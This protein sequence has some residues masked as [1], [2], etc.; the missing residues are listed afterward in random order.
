VAGARPRTLPAALSAVFAGAGAAL[1]GGSL[2]WDRTLLAAVV[3]LSLQV[4]VNYAN[5]YSDGIRG[6]DEVRSGPV[7]LVGQHLVA[8]KKVKVA[9]FG[10]F[11]VAGVAGLILAA[12]AGWWLIAVGVA[13]ILAAWYYTGGKHPY[14]YAGYG[15]VFTFV[16]FG[17]VATLGTEYVNLGT[18]TRVGLLSALGIGCLITALL[19]VN[20][21]RDI[22]GDRVSGKRT[23]A[24]R[25]SDPA[26]RKLYVV[27][28]GAGVVLGATA[29][30]PSI[31]G[32]T[33]LA[34]LALAIGPLHSVVKGAKA[35]KLIAVLGE[36]GRVTLV[37]GICM[38]GSAI[39]V[40]VHP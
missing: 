2:T 5:D 36:T 28:V 12:L 8:P 29:F 3:A 33:Q 10:A 1:L 18:V 22:P 13:S 31:A 37:A 15:E 25:M 30:V 35:K 21:L 39:I 32:L 6:T 9:A 34:P 24:V 7:R 26:T 27:L 11:G 40:K 23:L 19:V 14:G 20:N 17:L 38:L 4:G 16:F